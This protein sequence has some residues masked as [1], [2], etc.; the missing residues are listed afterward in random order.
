MMDDPEIRAALTDRQALAV[1]IFGEAKG[2]PVAG[3]AAV[4]CV[5]RNRLAIPRR[6]GASYRAVCHQRAAFSCWWK[7]GGLDN[8][9]QVRGVAET[10]ALGKPLP[11]AGA[12]LI[13]FLDADWIAER[14]ISGEIRDVIA[15]ATHYYNPA[16]MVPPGRVP[17]WAVG[18]TPA[19]TVG[20]HLFYAGVA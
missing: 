6:F 7:F 17:D 3:K 18:K 9:L 5:V 4:G 13:A 20:R 8:Y 1:T 10:F 14:I 19:A 16:A 12:A 11:L 2:E 15:G